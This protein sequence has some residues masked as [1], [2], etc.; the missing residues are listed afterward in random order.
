MDATLSNSTEVTDAVTTTSTPSVSPSKSHQS[1]S[2]ILD[3]TSSR[4][5]RKLLPK[6]DPSNGKDNTKETP[7]PNQHQSMS[8]TNYSER[9]KDSLPMDKTQQNYDAGKKLQKIAP[10]PSTNSTGLAR[11]NTVNKNELK[12]GK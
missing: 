11:Q 6:P 2:N 4:G 12:M 8:K 3:T 9:R 5:Y 1:A 7:M 10:H